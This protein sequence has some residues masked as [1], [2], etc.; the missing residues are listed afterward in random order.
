MAGSVVLLG[1]RVLLCI[2]ALVPAPLV[3]GC[4][5]GSTSRGYRM[6]LLLAPWGLHLRKDML[7]P[8]GWNARKLST[9]VFV[10]GRQSKV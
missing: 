10:S 7:E 8:N 9:R 2:I 4:V 5:A 6:R 3:A 1:I